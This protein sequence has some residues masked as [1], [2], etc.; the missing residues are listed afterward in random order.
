[1]PRTRLTLPAVAGRLERG[2]RPH[3]G[4]EP[5]SMLGSTEIRSAPDGAEVGGGVSGQFSA[6]SFARRVATSRR[7]C[8]LDLRARS[9]MKANSATHTTTM[10]Q[11]KSAGLWRPAAKAPMAIP[12]IITAGQ[13]RS[14]LATSLSLLVLIELGPAAFGWLR[15]RL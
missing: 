5:C 13:Y 1:V 9:T 14:V 11:M 7:S 15:R 3:R 10:Q 4:A 8:F 12:T 2:V 6:W